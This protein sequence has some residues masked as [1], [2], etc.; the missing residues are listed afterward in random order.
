MPSSKP[1]FRGGAVRPAIFGPFPHPD[2]PS[3]PAG[4]P[5]ETILADQLAEVRAQ[6]EAHGYA[7]GFSRGQA[8]AAAAFREELQR[9]H[10]LVAGAVHDVQATLRQLEPQVVDLVVAIAERVIERELRMDRQIVVGV[11]RAALGAA[12][13]LP[14]V[15]VRVHPDDYALVAEVWPELALTGNEPPVEL[16]A[17]PQVQAGG[18]IIDTAS[19]LVDAQPATRLAMIHEQLLALAKGPNPRLEGSR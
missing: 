5:S 3:A 6:A 2:R 10:R 16:V 7:E 13:S 9:F 15:R 12:G 14:V 1:V 17:D 18:C 19:G 8:A 4:E 11:V